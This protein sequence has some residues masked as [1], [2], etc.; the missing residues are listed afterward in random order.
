MT[1]VSMAVVLLR[2]DWPM[3]IAAL[4]L[5]V[6]MALYT[7]RNTKIMRQAMRTARRHEGRVSA[8]LQESLSY[9]KL[10]QAYGR[11]E[12]EASRLT[13]ARRRSLRAN[14][15]AATLLAPLTPSLPF[16]PS[17]GYTVLT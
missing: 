5:T 4:L 10:V 6:P 13:E 3:A 1:W 16:L 14:I 7:R 9:V 17:A 11:E 12:Q 15:C 8:V 2:L